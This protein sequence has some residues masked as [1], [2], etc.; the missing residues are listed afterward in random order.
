MTPTPAAVE[1]YKTILEL[2]RTRNLGGGQQGVMEWGGG[3]SGSEIPLS[4]DIFKQAFGPPTRESSARRALDRA[5]EDLS[6]FDGKAHIAINAIFDRDVGGYRDLEFY[7]ERAPALAEEAERGVWILVAMLHDTPL[8]APA[9]ATMSD[10]EAQLQ[11]MNDQ[12]VYDTWARGRGEGRKSMEVIREIQDTYGVS[13]RR[14]YQIL[15]RAK[16]PA[17]GGPGRPRKNFP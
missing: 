3:S 16:P 17:E 4:G 1:K 10:G 8:Y 13:E 7:R 6:S 14:V 12:A 9:P 11:E 2:L 15:E 5:L